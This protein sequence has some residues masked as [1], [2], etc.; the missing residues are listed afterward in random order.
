MYVCVCVCVC[1]YVLK[2]FVYTWSNSNKSDQSIRN[3]I[4]GKLKM[5]S[6]LVD[7][8]LSTTFH[9]LGCLLEALLAIYIH[10]DVVMPMI[11]EDA[12]SILVRQ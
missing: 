6:W 12:G 3:V 11:P 10:I 7:A 5:S 8:S 2:V 4:V 9:V 1:V